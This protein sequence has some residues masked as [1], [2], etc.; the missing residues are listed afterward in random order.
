MH[1]LDR[2]KVW[3]DQWQTVTLPEV[4]DAWRAVSYHRVSQRSQA[5]YRQVCLINKEILYFG[6]EY[7]YVKAKV[8]F[9]NERA[10]YLRY[11]VTITDQYL[12]LFL[13]ADETLTEAF[14]CSI[15]DIIG[16]WRPQKYQNGNNEIWIHLHHRKS[17]R[18]LQIL[19]SRTDMMQLVRAL[20]QITNENII[21]AYRR[22]CPYIHRGLSLAYPAVQDIHGAWHLSDP[23]YLFLMPLYLVVF[24]EGRI[25]YKMI[26]VGQIQ[27][28]AAFRRL[29]TLED[30]DQGLLRFT[31]ID[32]TLGDES[33][34]FSV[35]DY[36]AWAEDLAESAKRTLEDPIL[37]KRKDKGEDEA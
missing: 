13:I 10:P 6:R 22:R 2:L 19:T 21:T 20:K 33:F 7:G 5:I 17:W 28:I 24:M 3:Q 16:F 26:P 15:D 34:A 31:L 25:V 8:I 14:R 4:R 18:I 23:V 37:Q 11:C 9:P 30:A 27:D 29:D 1:W 12:S 32:S 36:Q 35:D